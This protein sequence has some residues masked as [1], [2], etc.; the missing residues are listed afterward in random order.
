MPV[1]NPDDQREYLSV[2]E[3]ATELN[4]SVATIRRRIRAGQLPAVR[5]G[6]DRNSVLRVP[7]A[8]LT[9]WLWSQPEEN[10]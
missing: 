10:D 1:T 8:A 7:R 3:I 4:C 6:Q 2:A 5:L 9:A